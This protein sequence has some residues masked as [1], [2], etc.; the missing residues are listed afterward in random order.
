MN[1][2]DLEEKNLYQYFNF[3]LN[4]G[5]IY[6]LCFEKY[7]LFE[8]WKKWSFCLKKCVEKGWMYRIF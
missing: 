1:L 4:M 6:I 2:F 7:L 5:L 3:N 8:K